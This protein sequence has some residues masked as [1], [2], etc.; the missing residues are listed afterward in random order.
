[1]FFAF[2]FKP[3]FMKQKVGWGEIGFQIENMV[4]N[5]AVGCRTLFPCSIYYTRTVG[6]HLMLVLDLIGLA[7]IDVITS[8]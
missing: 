6:Q 3:H 5:M 4:S 2:I 7:Y 8:I 1:M